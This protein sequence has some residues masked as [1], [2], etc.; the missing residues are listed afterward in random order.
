MQAYILAKDK[1]NTQQITYAFRKQ[2][3]VPREL[4][5]FHYSVDNL[6]VEAE[7]CHASELSSPETLL[8]R[9]MILQAGFE[10]PIVFYPKVTVTS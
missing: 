3:Y 10:A 6:T 7:N 4:R 5:S 9:S 8:I 2:K 1:Q